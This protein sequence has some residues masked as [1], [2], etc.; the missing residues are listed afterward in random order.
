VEVG[1]GDALPLPDGRYVEIAVHDEGVG[2]APDNLTRIFD[3]YFTTKQKRSG[4]GL[5]VAHSIIRSH[6]GL[7]TAE[8]TPGVGS[9]FRIFLAAVSEA[10]GVDDLKTLAGLP[11][12]AGRVLIMDDEKLVRET[13]GE[14]LTRMGYEVQYA[15]DGQEAIELYARRRQDGQPFDAVIMDL[16]VPGGMGG[17]EANARLR[18]MD[19]AAKTIV[20]SGYATDPIMSDFASFGFQGR[21]AK[22]YRMADLKHTLYQVIF[23]IDV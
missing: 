6:A 4:L 20:S 12:E 16:T 19:P 13:V 23:Q 3:P 14:M 18:E 17:I 10:Q 15:R 5:A 9:V 1:P 21:L 2:I 22:P 11:A 7:I 8:S